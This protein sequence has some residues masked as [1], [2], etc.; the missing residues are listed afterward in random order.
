M[1]NTKYVTAIKVIDPD[2]DEVVEI[3]I[4]K[5]AT[6]G[7]VGLDGSFLDQMSDDDDLFSP[8]DRNERILVPYDEM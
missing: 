7:M 2:T 5:M 8:Y 3:E 1:I 4:R 6:G